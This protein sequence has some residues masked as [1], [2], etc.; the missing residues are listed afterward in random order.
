[1]VARA[2]S[3]FWA[4]TTTSETE[5]SPGDAAAAARLAVRLNTTPAAPAS[6]SHLEDDRRKRLS[7]LSQD[8]VGMA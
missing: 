3:S 2:A 5:V 1:M 7:P 6:S 4:V 8:E